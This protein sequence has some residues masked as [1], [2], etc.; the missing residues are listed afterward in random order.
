M[1]LHCWH[2]HDDLFLTVVEPCAELADWCGGFFV[3]ER[4]YVG[5]FGAG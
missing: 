5:G 4:R 2:L 1:R 3:Y